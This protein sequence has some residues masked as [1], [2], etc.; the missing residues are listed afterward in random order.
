M[1]LDVW[2]NFIDGEA[3]GLTVHVASGDLRLYARRRGR[4]LDLGTRQDFTALGWGTICDL[5][6][7]DIRSRQEAP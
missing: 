3:N 2:D 6:D 4:H 1:G 7:E 5:I